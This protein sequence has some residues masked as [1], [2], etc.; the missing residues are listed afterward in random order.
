ML[1][2][3]DKSFVQG[4]VSESMYKDLKAKYELRIKQMEK[5]MFETKN[6]LEALEKERLGEKK[7]AK[8]EKREES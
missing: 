1:D 5:E 8:V 2:E 7:K 4:N 6:N 3:I